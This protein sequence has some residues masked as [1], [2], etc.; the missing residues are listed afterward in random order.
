MPI[1]IEL[2]PSLLPSAYVL[3]LCF[4]EYHIVILIHLYNK[5]ASVTKNDHP[6]DDFASKN[7]QRIKVS[8]SLML[9]YPL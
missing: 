3:G 6:S 2:P 1:S 7:P 8:F 5:L 4:V 9:L